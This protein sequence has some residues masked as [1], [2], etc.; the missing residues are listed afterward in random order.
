MPGVGTVSRIMRE[1]AEKRRRQA[2]EILTRLA[3]DISR[4]E[5]GRIFEHVNKAVQFAQHV[6][7]NRRRRLRFTVKKNR[8]IRIRTSDLVN[9]SAQLGNSFVFLARVREIVIVKTHD[10]CGRT[11]RLTRKTR[12]VG[13]CGNG[14]NLLPLRLDGLCKV[15]NAKTGNVFRMVILVNDDDR[16]MV[17]HSWKRKGRSL[18]PEITSGRRLLLKKNRR[19]R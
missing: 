6:V 7:R 18:P 13:K 2:F 15:S 19:L 9:K 14:A 5:L 12:E 4:H 17:F 11:A 10:K 16:E 8:H 3:H 1:S